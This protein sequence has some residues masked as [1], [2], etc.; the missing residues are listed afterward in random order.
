MNMCFETESELRSKGKP[1]TPDVLLLIPMAVFI[2]HKIRRNQKS[3]TFNDQ[4]SEL[5]KGK[6]TQYTEDGNGGDCYIVNWIDSKA[7]FADEFTFKENLDQFKSYVHRY[8]KGLVIYWFGFVESIL[9]KL[10]EDI[11]IAA[12]FPD[13]WIDPSGET[14]TLSSC[15]DYHRNL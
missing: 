11:I 12:S 4:N 3:V 15:F 13:K 7:I 8:G 14:V 1:K 9:E 10:D 5:M 2:P 6:C